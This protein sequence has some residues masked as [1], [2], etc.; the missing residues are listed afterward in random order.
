VTELDDDV[1][2]TRSRDCDALALATLYA[3]HAPGLLAFL[4]RRTSGREEAE[5][6]LQETFVRI[7]EGRGDFESRG[8]FR[9]WLY[10]IALR[11]TRDRARERQRRAEI[12]ETRYGPESQSYA[13]PT[14][15]AI[16]E[17]GR[18]RFESALRAL[19][20]EQS[21]ALQLR[22]RDGFSYR[23]MASL[24]GEP[25]GTL[26]SRVHHALRHIREELFPAPHPT[27]RSQGDPR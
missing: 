18:V 21:L 24:C 2:A 26:R 8:R 14:E 27:S 3:R 1:L 6:V 5:D 10:T 7:F 17:R 25:E 4:V 11:L 23:E 19:S 12:L 9:A 22:F 15:I 13:S 16:G 20:P